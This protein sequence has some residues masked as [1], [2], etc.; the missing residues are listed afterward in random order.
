MGI[1]RDEKKKLLIGLKT[2][3][4]NRSQLFLFDSKGNEIWRYSN[5][6]NYIKPDNKIGA[7]ELKDLKV[8]LFKGK[9]KI[10]A[11]F[12]D[13]S[14]Y[15][16]ILILLDN[17]GKQLKEF[18]H[19]G[20]MVQ[21]E[22]L[23]D[24]FVIRGYNNDFSQKPII[25]NN[26]N[27]PFSVIFGL[28]YDYI[29]GEAPPYLGSLERNIYF[30]WY[31]LLSDQNESF[32]N[33]KI[34]A[35]YNEI[36]TTATCGMRFYGDEKGIK[37]VGPSEN[38]SCKKSLQLIRLS[39]KREAD[40]TNNLNIIKE[41]DGVI[42]SYPVTNKEEGI[43][44]RRV[45]DKKKYKIMALSKGVVKI[46]GGKNQF[47]D[48]GT[49]IV[50]GQQANRLYI[51][52]ASHVVKDKKKVKVRFSIS[53]KSY[54]PTKDNLYVGK[55]IN[56]TK[57]R[58]RP[59]KRTDPYLDIA[60]VRVELPSEGLS[61][62]SFPKIGIGDV[63]RI[64]SFD[65]VISICYYDV[66]IFSVE[67]QVQRIPLGKKICITNKSKSIIPGC[68]GSPVFDEH[69]NILGITIFTDPMGTVATKIEVILRQLE[70]WG[71]STNLITASTLTTASI[72]KTCSLKIESTPS[73]SEIYINNNY[74][75]LTPE[76]I[77]FNTG[78]KYNLE[79]KKQGYKKY[80]IQ[81]DC[82]S[83]NVNA[84]LE[85]INLETL[86]IEW[87]AAFT[88]P[89]KGETIMNRGDFIV[90][91]EISD[92]DR[93]S[94]FHW[95]A[96]AS[97]TDYNKTWARVMELYEKS[98]DRYGYKAK[99]EMIKLISE[100]KIDI[101]WPKFYIPENPYLGHVY[102]NWQNPMK[103]LEPQPMIL[104]ILKVDD[105]LHLYF[106]QFL[107][108]NLQK[109]YPGISASKLAKN[110]ILARCEIFFP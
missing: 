92:F 59:P 28:K 101:F 36:L 41:P 90:T 106:K 93:T 104:L 79:I 68:S 83:K 75:G 62:T 85:K 99:G 109:G 60:V 32:N 73:K 44:K 20:H 34:M 76:T 56:R 40:G 24:V 87:K 67:N 4:N 25:S 9:E 33:L 89:Q 66:G 82:D 2:A 21:I 5:E 6:F 22:M 11:L 78:E 53:D 48:S 103:G 7:Y 46:I 10:A 105:A 55:V 72:L 91:L 1:D 17:N 110:M 77:E 54:S 107:R 39:I 3:D 100:W 31:Y 50:I 18:W 49:G 74:K 94:G 96:I 61:I 47:L 30:E 95:V 84:V 88:T 80:L 26:K 51:L 86:P 27:I 42:A 12:N 8:F 65:K 16:S 38:F 57:L 37:P 15:Q 19:P 29:Y 43:Y 45:K 13:S 71:I 69:E 108:E 23:K 58:K 14:W 63:S 64:N 97:V 52:T 35:G 102:D 81:I 98:R 70:E